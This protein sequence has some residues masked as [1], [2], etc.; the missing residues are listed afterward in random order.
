M[1]TV[2]LLLS[3]VPILMATQEDKSEPRRS[4]YW[5]SLGDGIQMRPPHIATNSKQLVPVAAFYL[6]TKE[7]KVAPF[8]FAGNVVV[9]KQKYTGTIKSYDA[10]FFDKVE[11]LLGEDADVKILYR[12]ITWNTL[13]IEYTMNAG[14]L[15]IH[16]YSKVVIGGTKPNVLFQVTATALAERWE[17]EKAQL[18][19]S[20]DSFQT[21]PTQPK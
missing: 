1:R 11:N 16:T 20:V 4:D 12:K 13:E 19:G 5:S 7:G 17:E 21:S 10:H 8:A 15:K 3:T 9:M 6:P 18:K 14:L 2:I